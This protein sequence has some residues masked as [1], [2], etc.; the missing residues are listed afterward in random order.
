MC[1]FCRDFAL[2][3]EDPPVSVE[4]LNVQDFSGMELKFLLNVGFTTNIT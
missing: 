4:P 3:E 2:L 1:F